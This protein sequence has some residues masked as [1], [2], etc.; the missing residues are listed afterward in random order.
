MRRGKQQVLL[1]YLPGCT[2]D[3]ER[4]SSI[5][6]VDYVSGS[7]RTDL[8]ADVVFT[9][10]KEEVHVWQETFR[11]GLRD[12]VLNE[13]EFVLLDPQRVQAGLFPK[14]FWCQNRGCGAIEDYTSRAGL[15]AASCRVCRSGRL[16]QLR[17]VCIHRCGE[18]L[19]LTPR[20]CR[21]GR[22][23]A[24]SL[25]LRGSERLSNFRWRCRG[26]GNSTSLF[27]GP[28]PA[29][30]W[31][32][33]NQR[34]MDAE[35]HRANRTYY[36]HSVTLLNVP[37]R[38]LDALLRTPTWPFMAAAK[39]LD[40]AETRGRSLASLASPGAANVPVRG[41]LTST[42]LDELLS[43]TGD[44]AERL[45]ELQRRRADRQIEAEQAQP[46][47]LA[48]HLV[49]ASGVPLEIWHAAGHELL[50][51]VLP[52][53]GRS[54]RSE[55]AIESD[56]TER[57]AIRGVG[58][59]LVTLVADFPI[60]T[61]TYGFTRADFA[62]N[63]ARLN[64]FPPDR[65]QSGRKPV[66]VDQVGADAL[67]LSLD[68]GRVVRWL[69]ANGHPP[70]LPGGSDSEALVRGYFVQLMTGLQLKE[71]IP[72]S[73]PAA[74]L[75]FGLVHTISHLA[76]RQ[77]TLLCGLDRTSLS[78]YLLPRGLMTAIYCN[79]RFGATIGALTALFETS[80]PDWLGMVGSERQC[81]YDPVCADRGA[82]CHACVH[83]P[84]TS[85]R[86]FNLNL[87]RSFVFG[88]HDS[89]LGVVAVGYFDRSLD[90]T[91]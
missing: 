89:E 29:C 61:A 73:D 36:P 80:I 81:V 76:I 26:C 85:C 13:R 23:D 10:I 72:G 15:P 47:P 54:T 65:A 32:D 39:F 30:T 43:G 53:E 8:S 75:V 25:D 56:G 41:E 5:A 87:S 50:D 74:R 46:E 38:Q 64:A 31:P 68:K 42:D 91:T 12:D 86:T 49:Q 37:D 55:S 69:E 4:A 35:V 40:L 16:S 44:P 22:A 20:P 27:V 33:A 88:G 6:R 83:L 51:I 17:W 57:E 90:R 11:P 52:F 19:P 84:E 21:C 79:H 63:S 71:T 2:F 1:H 70:V 62:P 14:V 18:L 3:G 82:N 67:V 78:E 34:N 59:D 9:R 28:C 7:P 24:F 45:A 58:L 60:L 77:A 66:F 48:E